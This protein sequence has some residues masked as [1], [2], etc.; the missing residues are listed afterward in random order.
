MEKSVILNVVEE[1]LFKKGKR[2]V[3]SNILILGVA[4]KKN[5]DDPRESPAWQIIK[6]L[7]DG[8]ATVNYSDPYIPSIPRVVCGFKT[9]SI[10]LTAKNLEKYDCVVLVTDHNDFDYQ[11]ICDHSKAIVDTRNAFK[12]ITDSEGKIFKA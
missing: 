3:D 11:F 12:F 2:L 9:I 6:L 7:L 5:S 10:P 8:G 4:Y 1:I